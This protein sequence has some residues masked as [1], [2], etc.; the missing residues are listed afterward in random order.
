MNGRIKI[1]LVDLDSH[2]QDLS[3]NI[4]FIWVCFKN[5]EDIATDFVI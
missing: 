2:D 5:K 3:E 4:Y 1:V